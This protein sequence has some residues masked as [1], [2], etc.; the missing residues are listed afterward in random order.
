MGKQNERKTWYKEGNNF[1]NITDLSQTCFQ[2]RWSKGTKLTFLL[3]ITEKLQNIG[4]SGSQILDIRQH[5]MGWGKQ[6]R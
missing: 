5:K 3:E 2:Q 6:T 1:Q 4:N